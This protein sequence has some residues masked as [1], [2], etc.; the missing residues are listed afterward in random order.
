MK[1]E[2]NMKIAN[3]VM[4]VFMNHAN[5]I[6]EKK[7]PMKLYSAVS[8][9]FKALSNAAEVF[10]KQ[11]GDIDDTAED[12]IK[13]IDEL[14]AIESEV[15]IQTVPESVFDMMDASTKFDALTGPEFAAIEFM[16]EK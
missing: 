16:I 14:L 8:Q 13:Q 9:N 5:T 12:A 7:I 11:R 6:I 10:M 3:R 4:V 2:R 15:P 1:G